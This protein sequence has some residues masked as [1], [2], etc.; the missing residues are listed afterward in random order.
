[1]MSTTF[2]MVNIIFTESNSALD[3]SPWSLADIF[4]ANNSLFLSKLITLMKTIYGNIFVDLLAPH[5]AVF[6]D[7]MCI[8][9]VA[10]AKHNYLGMK[11]EATK[12]D[13]VSTGFRIS[14]NNHFKVKYWRSAMEFYNQS[15][16][17]AV[18]GTEN[19]SLAYANRSSCFLHM[20]KYNE[21]LKDIEIARENNYPKRSMK[22]LDEREM[23]CLEQMKEAIESEVEIEPMLSFD[24]NENFPCLA[25]TLEIQTN[26]EYGRHIVA[27]RDI[28]VGQTVLIEEPYVVVFDTNNRTLCLTCMKAVKN[29]IPCP[30]C[31]DAMFCDENCMRNN[32]TH[33]IACGYVF[34][35]V[36]SI[37]IY[38]QSILVA[39]NTFNTVDHLMEFVENQLATPKF[40]L[41]KSFPDDLQ[42]KYLAKYGMFLK[43]TANPKEADCDEILNIYLAFKCISMIPIIK[44]SFDTKRKK[45]FL[46]HLIL[47]HRLILGNGFGH[48]FPINAGNIQALCNV[49]SLFNHSCAPN[50]L[51]LFV[52]NKQILFQSTE[53]R[54]DCLKK[55]F[56]FICKCNRCAPSFRPI[57]RLTKQIQFDSNFCYIYANQYKISTASREQLAIL[58]EKCCEFLR[59]YS[60]L[61]WSGEISSVTLNFINCIKSEYPEYNKTII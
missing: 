26:K 6:L 25:I 55:T 24:S 52:G 37:Q 7:D 60:Q 41:P 27:N 34:Y 9:T 30:T 15:L 23:L 36:P 19:L 17:F 11:F 48:S 22:K 18:K 50:I 28:D 31:I 39:L 59:K 13:L 40:D 56:R 42:T 3:V 54:Q 51:H 16:R 43:L 2:F 53:M 35:R 12:S 29:F 57:N 8:E 14:G 58:K 32:D 20:K 61:T 33:K 46:M 21:C 1:M 44:A 4:L 5:P 45:R 47:Q 38:I 10:T 49:M